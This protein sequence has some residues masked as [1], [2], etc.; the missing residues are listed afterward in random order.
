[1]FNLVKKIKEVYRKTEVRNR[2]KDT[3]EE[4][5]KVIKIEDYGDYNIQIIYVND[6]INKSFSEEDLN[7]IEPY[8]VFSIIF[9]IDKE[10]ITKDFYNNL[11]PFLD[12][13]Q[14]T[15]YTTSYDSESRKLYSYIG[16][17]GFSLD[18]IFDI[19]YSK[20]RDISFILSNMIQLIHEEL[21][22]TRFSEF[23]PIKFINQVDEL[24]DYKGTFRT[25]STSTYNILGIDKIPN[26]NNMFSTDQLVYMSN[27][28]ICIEYTKIQDIVYSEGF[29]YTYSLF[30]FLQSIYKSIDIYTRN[31]DIV[32]QIENDAYFTINGINLRKYAQ[33]CKFI[34]YNIYNDES[35]LYDD[36]DEVIEENETV[37]KDSSS[38]SNTI[39][40][41]NDDFDD[42]DEY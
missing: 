3:D 42:M 11:L 37:G 9:D 33:Q 40:S 1:M 18:F 19:Y 20:G 13:I 35:E 25:T 27:V 36:V 14:S 17:Y 21:N 28:Y 38:I 5:A 23:I 39:N 15:K 24:P 10:D 6:Y 26:V 12:T 7:K 8:V 4:V 16:L 34:K 41:D 31:K 29:G 32:F 30:K 2:K 22:N